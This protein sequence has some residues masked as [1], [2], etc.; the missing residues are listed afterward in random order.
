MRQSIFRICKLTFYIILFF[1]SGF[2]QSRDELLKT[3]KLRFKAMEE[4]DSVSLKKILDEELA[5][6]HSN[7]LKDGQQ[8]LIASIASGQ[9]EYQRIEIEQ[10]EAR[11]EGNMGWVSGKLRV[12]VKIGTADPVNLHLSYLDIYRFKKNQW[13]MLAWQ[14]A[15][16]PD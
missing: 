14:S 16:L 15:R 7:G 10:V 2:G 11:T 3:E 9:V 1:N 12:R 13:R 5:Y 6:N 4:K 8:S